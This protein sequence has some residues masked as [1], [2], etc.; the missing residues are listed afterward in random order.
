MIRIAIAEDFEVVLPLLVLRHQEARHGRRLSLLQVC[1][2][3]DAITNGGGTIGVI[4]DTAIVVAS[5]ALVRCR[6]WWTMDEHYEALWNFVH[7]EH[8]RTDHAKDLMNFAKAICDKANLPLY[9]SQEETPETA[10]KVR[11]LERQMTRTAVI[12]SHEPEHV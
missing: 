2:Q 5:I 12:F 4:E 7:P 11:L 1:R 8:R 6:Y 10:P 3:Y 9:L